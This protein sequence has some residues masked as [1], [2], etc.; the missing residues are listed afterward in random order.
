MKITTRK[1][2]IFLIFAVFT[3]AVGWDVIVYT[4]KTPG[5]E[6]SPIMA[7]W[8]WRHPWIPF[9]WGVLTGHLFWPR[10]MRK[11]WRNRMNLTILVFGLLFLVVD[12]LNWIPPVVPIIPVIIGVP[13][14]F[15]FWAQP[16]MKP[17]PEKC[18]S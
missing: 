1:I 12:L 5:D 4:N 3:L 10:K 13:L 16:K 9:A 8:S 14:G 6:I 17:E 15:V 2:T 18:G 11:L 7:G